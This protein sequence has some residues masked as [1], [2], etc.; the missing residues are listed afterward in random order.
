MTTTINGFGWVE[1]GNTAMNTVG[2]MAGIIIGGKITA[3]PV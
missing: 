3:N 2:L 1:A